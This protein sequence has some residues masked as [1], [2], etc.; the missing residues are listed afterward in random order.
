MKFGL[1]AWD[2]TTQIYPIRLLATALRNDG[3]DIK[4]IM[5][6][7]YLDNFYQTYDLAYND[8]K[9]PG[10]LTM[11][12]D[13]DIIAFSFLSVHYHIARYFAKRIKS[14]Y[15]EKILICGGIHA[16]VEPE[17]TLEFSDYVCLGEG[18]LVFPELI[19]AIQTNSSVQIPGVLSK[20]KRDDCFSYAPA[21]NKLDE[22]PIPDYFFDSTYIYFPR[23]DTWKNRD[24]SMFLP[25]DNKGRSRFSYYLFPD[26]GCV[27]N[28]S[29]CCRP[30]LKKLSKSNKIRFRSIE[31]IMEE[32]K[33]AKESLPN[34]QKVMIYSDDFF[35]WRLEDLKAFI[36]QYVE[37]IKLPFKFIFSPL[38]YDDNKARLLFDSGLVSSIS[39][40]IQTG[41][42]KMRKIYRRPENNKMIVGMANKLSRLSK[43]YKV[44]IG[45]DFIID[46]FWE[47]E[48]DRLETLKLICTMPK[49]FQIIFYS[50]TFY[51]GTALYKKAIEE[52]IL[53]EERFLKQFDRKYSINNRL[54]VVNKEIDNFIRLCKLC[55]ILPIPRH[56]AAILY[57]LKIT[58]PNFGINI[59]ERIIFIIQQKGMVFAVKYGS[60]RLFKKLR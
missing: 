46:A 57:I 40:G 60:Q 32:I 45:Y 29:Y 48:Q 38:N 37:F 25:L 6:I 41:S 28:C 4:I 18:E 56:F 53:T 36:E 9:L 17:K 43:A 35:N 54:K 44:L 21:L 14:K 12:E 16:S 27:F 2:Y 3:N 15:P 1:I 26:R 50:L 51:P 24:A 52:G 19:K 34:L 5:A 20:D 47:D 31:H 8:K 11:L 23:L 30:L 42:Q 22:N 7:S 55:A 10:I 39:A 49:P 58:I 59:L 33:V 13:R